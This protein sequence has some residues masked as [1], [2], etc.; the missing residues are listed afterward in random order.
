MELTSTAFKQGGAIPDKHTCKGQNIPP[1]L[2]WRDVPEGTESLALV[3]EDP[4]APR[5][6]FT[7]WIAYNID[8][9]EPG[10]PE[11]PPAKEQQNGILLGENDFGKK[12]YGGPCPPRDDGPHRYFFRLYALDIP[13]ELPPGA[14]K[15]A[16]ERAIEGHV[17]DQAELLGLYEIE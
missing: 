7:H 15:T 14:N 4:D 13:L 3:V 16:L 5:G 11:G 1:D 2:A 6:T 17:I 9:E 8:P 12:G 10:L